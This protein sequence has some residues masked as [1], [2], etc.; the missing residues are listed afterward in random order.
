M[1]MRLSYI[2]TNHTQEGLGQKGWG[3][4]LIDRESTVGL[5]A[6]L[7][8][9][10]GESPGCWMSFSLLVHGD[11]QVGYCRSRKQLTMDYFLTCK[12]N[13]SKIG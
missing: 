6:G 3:K 4:N 7:A 8:D 10:N 2:F 9:P 12:T 13:F 5:L 1:P 11:E